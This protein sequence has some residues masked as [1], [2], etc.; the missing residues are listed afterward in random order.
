MRALPLLVFLAAATGCN[1]IL[2]IEEARLGD[3]SVGAPGAG[4]TAGAGGTGGT[5][6]EGGGACSLT[7]PD[8]CNQCV[9][10]RCCEQY[11][12]CNADSDCKAAL[13]AY[14]VC[15][16][17]DFTNDAGGTCDETFGASANPLRSALA[18]CAFQNGPSASPPG[19]NDVCFG[20][21]VGGD[22]CTTYCACVVEAC[23]EKSFDGADCLAVCAAFT[24]PQLTCRPYH[25]GL[26]KAAKNNNNEP[27]RLTHCGHT[28]GEAL[29][30]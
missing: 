15:V 28:F 6:G 17:V 25:C 26:A 29:C 12:A 16:G 9:A 3:A 8:T 13:T 23:P 19:C 20:K 11:D 1:G 5:G 30:P 2:G 24:E 7:A 10:S 4:G 21:P 18:T 14:N 22:I 27:Q